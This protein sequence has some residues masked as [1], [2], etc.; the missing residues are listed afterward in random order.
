MVIV[1][2]TVSCTVLNENSLLGGF[3]IFRFVHEIHCFN[4]KEQTDLVVD[5]NFV[6]SAE[7]ALVVS[8]LLNF[9]WDNVQL[10]TSVQPYW[11]Q[12]VAKDRNAG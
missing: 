2:K 7:V 5:E 3:K 12:T 1:Q 10:P 9:L 4:R 6:S 8:L 11:H